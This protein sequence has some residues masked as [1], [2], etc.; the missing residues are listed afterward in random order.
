MRASSSRIVGVGTLVALLAGLLTVIAAMPA[1][2]S[3]AAE[4]EDAIADRATVF[5]ATAVEQTDRYARVEVAEVWRGPDLAPTVWLQTSSAELAPWPLRL[6]L[7]ASTS[8]DAQLVPGTRYLIATQDGGFRTSTCLVTEASEDLVRRL[9]PETT[10]PPIA[11]GATGAEPGVLDGTSGVAV[12]IALIAALPA[13]V[14][15]T[16]RRFRPTHPNGQ[17]KT[18]SS[19][20]SA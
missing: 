19:K 11:S 10:R 15:M 13:G 3:C 12:A 7:R 8:V 20:G 17:G 1:H 9:A 6:V 16:Y 18:V 4:P 14:W 5:L 2:A